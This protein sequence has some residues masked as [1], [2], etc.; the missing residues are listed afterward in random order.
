MRQQVQQPARSDRDDALHG[1]RAGHAD[2]HG[3]AT[4]TG[5]QHERGDQG[6]VRELDDE[7][8]QERD[9]EHTEDPEHTLILPDGWDPPDWRRIHARPA[10]GH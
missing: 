8:G 3:T 10:P 9:R 1:E 7:D 2:Q 4:V 5:R 6:L